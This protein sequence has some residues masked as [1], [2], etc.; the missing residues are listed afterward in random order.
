MRLY[1]HSDLKS[2]FKVLF[3][4]GHMYYVDVR[5]QLASSNLLFCRF[6]ASNLGCQA[7]HQVTLCTELFHWF[8]QHN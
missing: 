7:W 3:M 4:C 8:K 6:Q 1:K 5:G 2:L